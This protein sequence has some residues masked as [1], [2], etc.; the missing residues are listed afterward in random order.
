MLREFKIAVCGDYAIGK[1]SLICSLFN[2]KL[3]TVD[4]TIGAAYR[5]FMS[6]EHNVKLN[7]W[8]TAGQERFR[9]LLPMYFRD[10]HIIL[11][12]WDTTKPFNVKYS[13]S[14][15]DLIR[16]YNENC[17]I[18]MIGTKIDL[19]KHFPNIA[20]DKFAKEM[21]I[22]D[23][24]YTSAKKRIGVVEAFDKI[25]INVKNTH[26][27]LPPRLFNFSIHEPPKTEKCCKN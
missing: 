1:T 10:A 7:I 11:Y 13:Q 6:R 16:N 12:C 9:A 8:D 27:D 15:I 18:Y 5:T 17:H 26:I 21:D 24:F 2:E 14:M 22:K 25:I 20:A 3:E 23:F 19:T 4:A